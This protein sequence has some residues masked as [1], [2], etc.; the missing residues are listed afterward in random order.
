MSFYQVVHVVEGKE[1][2]ATVTAA[3]DIAFNAARG[4]KGHAE[5]IEWAGGR[6]QSVT[7]VDS[8]KEA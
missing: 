7:P 1:V 3:Q 4:L 5:V 2:T 6:V 8:E